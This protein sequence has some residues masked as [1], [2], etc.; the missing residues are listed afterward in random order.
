MGMP[1]E[2]VSVSAGMHHVICLAFSSLLKQ[3]ACNRGSRGALNRL[4]GSATV[5]VGRKRGDI[6]EGVERVTYCGLYCGLCKEIDLEAWIA[7]QQKRAKTG[8]AYVDIR[9]QPCEVPSD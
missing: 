6:M 1:S 4:I 8:L 9:C 5:T 3:N 7:E 2:S